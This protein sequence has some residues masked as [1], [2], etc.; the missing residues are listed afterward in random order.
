[1]RKTHIVLMA[2]LVSFSS[3]LAQPTVGSCVIGGTIGFSGGSRDSSNFGPEINGSSSIMLLDIAPRIG[4]YTSEHIM[5]GIS[6]GYVLYKKNNIHNDNIVTSTSS[7]EKYIYLN[8]YLRFSWY[9]SEYWGIFSDLSLYYQWGTSEYSLYHGRSTVAYETYK[10]DLTKYSMQI[11][12]GIAFNLSNRISL[13]ASASF[14]Y[15]SKMSIELTSP[16]IPNPPN[17][18]GDYFD[19]SLDLTNF[20]LG[21]SVVL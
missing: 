8:P 18:E 3:T 2:L 13:E 7:K 6:I 19:I 15:L 20:R 10:A 11:R 9:F 5:N 1:M 17:V 14:I 12:P 4:Y 21:I 16:Q